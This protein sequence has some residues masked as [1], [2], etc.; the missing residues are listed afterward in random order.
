MTASLQDMTPDPPERLRHRVHGSGDLATFNLVG[1]RVAENLLEALGSRLALGPDSKILDFGCGCG[2]VITHFR[3]AAPGDLY[4]T[5]IDSEAIAW[6]QENLVAIGG[7][8]VNDER[9]PLPYADAFFDLIYS[10]SVFTHLPEGRQLAWLSELR[11]V[12]KPGGYLVLSTHGAGM[13]TAVLGMQ[14]E[15]LVWR[16]RVKAAWYRR[17][18]E[19]RGFVYTGGLGTPGLPRFYGSAVHGEKYIRTRWAALFE[20][21][22]ILPKGLNQHQDLIVCRRPE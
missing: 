12:T 15:N 13:L 7:F 2:R 9:P 17:L 5:D 1:A 8:S 20:I 6:C 18:L 16:E 14:R 22:A 19:R 10:V 4:G 3:R 21:A 11:R